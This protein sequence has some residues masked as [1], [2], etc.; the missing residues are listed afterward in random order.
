MISMRISSDDYAGFAGFCF[1]RDVCL[2]AS[3]GQRERELFAWRFWGLGAGEMCMER[4]MVVVV[5]LV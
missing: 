4:F 2:R 5:W 3:S 1:I